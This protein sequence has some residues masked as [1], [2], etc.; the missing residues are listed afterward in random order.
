MARRR[1]GDSQP[2]GLAGTPSPAPSPQR[3]D[4]CF[5]HRLLGD[6]KVAETA[7]QLGDN[8]T[9]FPADDAGQYCIFSVHILPLWSMIGRISTA[10]PGYCSEGHSFTM[11]IAASRSGTSIMLNPPTFSFA[12]ENG[13]STTTGSPPSA[14][15]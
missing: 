4:D 12:S 6:I 8:Q 11:A 1:A 15:T 3:N 2:P 14:R 7:L 9:G 13:P 5:L 10:T